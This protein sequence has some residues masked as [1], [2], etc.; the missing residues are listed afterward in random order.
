MQ[1]FSERF[2]TARKIWFLQVTY[3]QSF[4]FMIQFYYICLP[5]HETN[6]HKLCTG[7]FHLE[8]KD[9]IIVL[10]Y[11]I[12]YYVNPSETGLWNYR[13]HVILLS[14]YLELAFSY[15]IICI[16]NTLL[17]P[18]Q[19][20]LFYIIQVP[21]HWKIFIPLLTFNTE[22]VNVEQT[23]LTTKKCNYCFFLTL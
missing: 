16:V 1:L 7:S 11:K 20:G 5:F 17:H 3:F 4:S 9:R 15:I 21:C 19:K 14:V 12:Y 10:Y 8:S 23:Q 2:K 22:K 13:E 18:V 6:L